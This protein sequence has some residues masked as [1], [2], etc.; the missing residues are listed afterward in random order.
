VTVSWRNQFL[1]WFG[2]SLLGGI[3]FGDW[4]AM[5]RENRFAVDPSYWLRAAII[6]LGSFGNSLARRREE[7][8]Y[9]EEI[10]DTIVDP[11]V[12]V[13]GVWRSGT[14]HLQNLFAVDGRFA[15]PNWYQVAYPHTF[16]STE[17]RRSRALGFFIPET[18]LQD[19]MKYG[20]ALPAED[21]FALCTATAHSPMM[22]WI[23]PRRAKY[24]DRYATL[25]AVSEA[26][27]SE[28]KAALLWFVKKLACK[29][30]K[31]VVLKS[32]F[33][34]GRIRLLLDVFPEARFVHIHRDP[35]AVYQSSCH[36]Q[37]AAMKYCTLQ[38]QELDEQERTIHQ[39]KEVVE[40]FFAEKD[41]IPEGRFHELRYEDMDRDPVGQMRMAYEAL[42]LPDF[43]EVEPSVCRY[44][45]SIADYQKNSYADLEPATKERIGREW[46][47]A[48]SAWGYPV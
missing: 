40:A 28:W 39:Y 42:G 44:V 32:P 3:T 16:L 37:R 14:T 18:R 43:G 6:T 1:L 47:T 12:F 48:F 26:E 15:F 17:A 29:Y 25:G 13:L 30:R 19:N 11:P 24:Y 41:L 21:E 10:R 31:P 35:Y 4:W 23:F 34:T 7:A 33:H 36:T 22:S 5:L 46:Q 8:T 9:G 38:R 27:L 20:L 45:A 2:P